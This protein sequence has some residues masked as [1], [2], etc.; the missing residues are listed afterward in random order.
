MRSAVSWPRPGVPD[1]CLYSPTVNV[2]ETERVNKDEQKARAGRNAALLVEPGMCVGLGTG[3]T[4]RHAI[5]ELGRRLQAA[6]VMGVTG[7]PTSMTA[8]TLAEEAGIPVVELG[9]EAIDITIDGAD[10]IAP[11]LSLIKGAGGALLRE[12]IVAAAAKIFVVVADES[13]LVETLGATMPVPVE[14]APFGH[15]ST[16]AS[17]GELGNA[18]LRTSG[19]R[20]FLTDNGNLIADVRVQAVPNAAAFDRKLLAIP[21]VLA[22]GLFYDMASLALVADEDAIHELRVN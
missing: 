3:S 19:D 22:T 12:K 7:V 20:A 18:V 10:E 2:R 4:A 9:D 5:I 14:I 11:D 8:A 21:G 6:E 16:L 13:K 15:R 1:R 17:L